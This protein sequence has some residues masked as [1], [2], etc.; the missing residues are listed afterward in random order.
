MNIAEL[1]DLAHQLAKQ[2]DWHLRE[3]Q[4]TLHPAIVK[5]VHEFNM[6]VVD[7]VQLVLEWPHVSDDTLRLAFTR[8]IEHGQSNRQ[9]LT[10]VAKYLSRHF[11]D[12]KPNI[13]RDIASLY[14]VSGC[15]FTERHADAY[16][17]V[18]LSGPPSCMKWSGM[19]LDGDLSRHPYQVYAPELGWHMAIHM[20][21]NRIWGRCLCLDHNQRKV[22][23][24]SYHGDP[25][26]S[27]YSQPDVGLEAW[28]KEQGYEHT[29]AWPHGARLL[30]IEDNYGHL[31]A[32]YLDG[33]T[34]T[35]VDNGSELVIS[36]HGGLCCDCTDGSLSDELVSCDHCDDDVRRDSLTWVGRGDSAQVC[37]NC[38]EDH[39]EWVIGARG[40]EYYLNNDD[41]V[42][43]V[44]GTWYD[45]SYLGENGIVE[46]DC[47][48]HCG[49]Y[50]HSDDT[51]TD[52]LGDRWHQNDVDNGLVMLDAG[53]HQGEYANENDTWICQASGLRYGPD[54]EAVVIDN[55][56]YSAE[57]DLTTIAGGDHE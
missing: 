3:Q 33:D 49:E 11:P 39:Y 12:T 29:S 30:R 10:S 54:D 5:A 35:V 47:G 44:D 48:A 20:I 50:A 57:S 7:P 6:T 13:I 46:L 23:V 1:Y 45:S 14:T 25:G 18:A 15:Q 2:H 22:F 9:T 43:A 55:L 56:R 51:V 32:P 4:A 38:L 37:S 27:A 36:E 21:D 42:K 52:Y 41:C 28:L 31:L 34:K 40:N 8:S 19:D 26:K 16:V 17:Q 53:V 24:R